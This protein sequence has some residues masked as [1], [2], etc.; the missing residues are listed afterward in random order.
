MQSLIEE[1]ESSGNASVEV[2]D[3]KKKKGGAF[4]GSTPMNR[5]NNPKKPRRTLKNTTV[6]Q[7][8]TGSSLHWSTSQITSE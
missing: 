5:C 1:I 7:K 3:L 4:K 2:W 8:S 6:S